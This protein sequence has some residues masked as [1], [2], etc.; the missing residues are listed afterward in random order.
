MVIGHGSWDPD[1]D[2]KPMVA[3]YEAL[4]AKAPDYPVRFLLF[5]TGKHGAPVRM[6][7]W[8]D[9]LNWIASL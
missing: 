4:R 3:F 9:T 7:D 6:I 1:Y 5:D 8:R 2:Y